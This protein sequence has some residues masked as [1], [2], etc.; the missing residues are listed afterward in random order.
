RAYRREVGRLVVGYISSSTYDLLPL[1]LLLYRERFP[2]IEVALR[3]LTT[4]EQLRALEEDI[5]PGRT[6]APTHQRSHAECRGGSSRTHRVRPPGGT[7]A[8]RPSTHRRIT[9]RK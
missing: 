3:E 2:D 5:N 7:S 9:A 6:A 1:T 4:R 8:R